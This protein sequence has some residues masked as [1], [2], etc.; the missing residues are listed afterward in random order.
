M[1]LHGTWMVL[2]I[3]CCWPWAAFAQLQ[4]LPDQQPQ[5]VFAGDARKI[6]VVWHNAGDNTAEAEIRARIS[7]T[8]S[9]TAIRPPASADRGCS[10]Q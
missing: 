5:R 1:K 10:D 6:A 4:L 7:Q 3:A 9:A 2:M 8:S